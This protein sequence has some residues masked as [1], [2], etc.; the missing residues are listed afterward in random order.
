MGWNCS[1]RTPNPIGICLMG[2]ARASRLTL[3]LTRTRRQS[4][5]SSDELKRYTESKPDPDKRYHYRYQAASLAWEASKL[6]PN[7]SEETARLL[8]RAG[9]WLK[10]QD[11]DTAD[12]FYKTLVRRCR[13]TDIG[14]EADLI[15]WFPDFDGDGNL[16]R[17]RL[18]QL[19][20]PTPQELNSDEALA[21]YPIPGKHFVAQPGDHVRY[22]AAA[23]QRQGVSITAKDIYAANPEITPS[24]DITGHEI[25]IPTPGIPAQPMT[26][27]TTP[28]QPA[29]P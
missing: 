20:L 5:A 17:T 3:A 18:E 25:L 8:C 27:P 4:S 26:Q 24:D 28:D 2:A 14:A 1:A 22:I 13:K 10:A 23:V 16:I 6:M 29:P 12:I 19:D 9:S 7:N 11:P 15:R 21:D